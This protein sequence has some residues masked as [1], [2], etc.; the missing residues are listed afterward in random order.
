VD[1]IDK[2]WNATGAANFEWNFEWWHGA[3]FSWALLVLLLAW[4]FRVSGNERSALNFLGFAGIVAALPPQLMM[5]AI[6]LLLIF[7]AIRKRFEPLLLI[8]I[9]FGGLLANIPFAQGAASIVDPEGFLGILYGMGVSNGLFPLLIFMGVG[10]MTDFG[11]LIARPKLAL[12]GAAAQFGI[13]VTLIG[14][15][16]LAVP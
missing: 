2:L 9:G 13:F 4:A 12:L 15:L 11:P 6:S 16:G 10:A 7:L 8:P 5:I 1:T 14:A 3:V